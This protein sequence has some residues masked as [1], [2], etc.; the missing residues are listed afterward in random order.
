MS[1]IDMKWDEMI[2]NDRKWV[3]VGWN[4]TKTN[5]WFEMVPY[6]LKWKKMIRNKANWVKMRWNDIKW[7]KLMWN[8]ME[9]CKMIANGLK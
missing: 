5:D 1:R 9:W 6:K 7:T 4:G 2:H 8:N 3:Q